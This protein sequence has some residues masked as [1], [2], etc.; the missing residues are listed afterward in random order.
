MSL[1]RFIEAQQRD[2]ETALQ[3]VKQGKKINHWMWYI[4]PQI[5]SLG[6]SY[7]AKYYALKSIEETIE[8]LNNDYLYNNIIL[9]CE[10]LLEIN[11]SDV[12]KI[13]SDI[14]AIK[15]R[16][17][18]TIFNYVTEYYPNQINKTNHIVFQQVL[19]K[20]FCGQEDELTLEIIYKER[21][22]FQF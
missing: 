19:N 12:E 5:H 21:D 8:Y 16:S 14:D 9:I 11:H 13:F 10:A 20:F 4:F 3:E 6:E 1:N 17:S 18:M 7:Y 22:N 15:L 2:Y